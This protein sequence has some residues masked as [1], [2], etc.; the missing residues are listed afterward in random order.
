MLIPR[1][2]FLKTSLAAGALAS[3]AKTATA[4]PTENDNREYYEL[5]AYRLRPDGAG[6]LLDRYLENALIGGLRDRRCG[7]IGVFNE[8]SAKPEGVH[9]PT[10]WVVIPHPS[11][12]SVLEIGTQFN[13][14]PEIVASAGG[15]FSDTQKNPAVARIDSWLSVAFASQPKLKLPAARKNPNRIFELRTYESASEERALAKIDMFNDGEVP[16]M[17][18]V[19]LS[20]VFFGQTLIGGGLPQLTYMVSGENMAAH[21]EHWKAFSA[22]P[23]WNKLKSDPRYADTVNKVIQRFLSPTPYSEV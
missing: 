1:R 4:A 18:E 15:Y 20:P 16:V 23:T 9:V 11:L 19:G 13:R 21:D 3:V 5:R 10:V 22:H 14:E 7:P 12:T 17:H 8:N 6:D 2:T